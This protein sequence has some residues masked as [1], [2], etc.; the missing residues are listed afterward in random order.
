M[1]GEHSTGFPTINLSRAWQSFIETPEENTESPPLLSKIGFTYNAKFDNQF[2]NLHESEKQYKYVD[3]TI[4]LS[5]RSIDIIGGAVNVSPS[6]DLREL[7]SRNRYS[8][9][10]GESNG[11]MEWGLFPRHTWNSQVRFKSS[12]R[13]IYN[14]AFGP[15]KAVLH[16]VEPSLSAYYTPDFNEYFFHDDILDRD[17][18]LFA[19]IS[20]TPRERKQIGFSLSNGIKLKWKSVSTGK[21]E[22]IDF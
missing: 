4:T 8:Y 14:P 6:L 17:M 22:K 10:A 13:G 21:V 7:W 20:S 16:T 9:T 19:G 12:L 3:Q 2:R 1:N 15:V 5:G 18:D 11:R